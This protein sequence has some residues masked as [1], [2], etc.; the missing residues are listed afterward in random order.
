MVGAASRYG[1]REKIEKGRKQAGK[2]PLAY[3][4]NRP[5]VLFACIC[6]V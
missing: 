5:Y 1:R 3:G 2:F 6:P 4:L